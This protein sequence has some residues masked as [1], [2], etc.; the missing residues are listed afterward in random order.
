MEA[1]A[2]NEIVQRDG[3]SGYTVT[4]VDNGTGRSGDLSYGIL[5][6]LAMSGLAEQYTD[7][8]LSDDGGYLAIY[9]DKIVIEDG[10]TTATF[11]L[12]PENDHKREPDEDAV[13][14]VENGTSFGLTG[15]VY[16]ADPSQG[17]DSVTILD[18][19]WWKVGITVP[20]DDQLVREPG[21][22]QPEQPD[23]TTT[24]TVSRT[25]SKTVSYEMDTSY[26]MKVYLDLGLLAV[27]AAW[28]GFDYE[29]S[30]GL[31][32]L[33]YWSDPSVTIPAGATERLLTFRAKGDGLPEIEE[34]AP[35][36]VLPDSSP[37]G[38][39]YTVD[40]GA[41]QITVSLQDNDWTVSIAAGDADASEDSDET[42][43]E[44]L[45]PGQ[46][47]ITRSGSGPADHD[48][49]VKF[50]IPY[51]QAFADAH[52]QDH[53]D[54]ALVVD[55]AVHGTGS[56]AAVSLAYDADTNTYRGTATIPNGA[57]TLAVKLVPNDDEYLELDEDVTPTVV[58]DDSGC[59]G[60]EPGICYVVETTSASA[61][62]TIED[63]DVPEL[64]AVTY[65]WANYITT[66]PVYDPTFNN[67]QFANYLVGTLITEDHWFD[68]SV[69][70][71][72]GEN[73]DGY[74]HDRSYPAS[75]VR[76]TRPS[77]TAEWMRRPEP[78][79]TMFLRGDGPDSIDAPWEEYTINGANS[80]RA[81]FTL[82]SLPNT[83]K[84]FE[85][86]EINWEYQV[87]LSGASTPSGGWEQAGSSSTELYVTLDTPE[88]APL[89]HTVVYTGTKAADGKSTESDAIA[90]IWA[91]FS[92]RNVVRRDNTR[93]T[94]YVGTVPSV[95]TS[96][97]LVLAD[98]QCS[99]WTSFL[100]DTL[101][102]HGIDATEYRV[103]SSDPDPTAYLM[104]KE[105]N[106]TGPGAS[107]YADYRYILGYDVIPGNPADG[108]GNPDPP[109]L[110]PVHFV[111][112]IGS[113]YYDPSYG[114]QAYTSQLDWETATLSGFSVIRLVNGEY[115]RVGK[116]NS[117]DQ[118]TVFTPMP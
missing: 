50:T 32:P 100:I 82:W 28:P 80:S 61:T 94:Y 105:W 99:A 97:L 38:T 110:F 63:N 22:G 43:G 9:G 20:E 25:P 26:S 16:G 47:Q 36:T 85:S 11:K 48:L 114:G 58:P 2:P 62:V 46:F 87:A 116:T 91:E 54:Y 10:D 42:T 53:W 31:L 96:H 117:P 111:V 34:V 79:Y 5:V 101:G 77:L 45:N 55:E 66:D 37:D 30:Q 103:T 67:G 51:S 89:F 23:Q 83:I 6:D 3:V 64:Y 44:P 29:L 68:V 98:G 75:Y 49:L 4:R 21:E 102:A 65:E 13:I 39:P 88:P 17:S 57:H 86:F 107:G 59:Y 84:Y 7:Y 74:P 70:N 115:K 92:D 19:D 71:E 35:I 18:D 112:R 24:L 40:N 78:G 113:E 90:A 76:N 73:A 109:N 106:F 104:V 41:T 69:A 118:D 27:N 8:N 56:G 33:S 72:A 12:T 81:L 60:A 15:G 52:P 14:S 93:L 1:N 108:Q 95:R